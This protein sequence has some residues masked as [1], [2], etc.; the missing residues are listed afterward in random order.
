MKNL[1]LPLI[2][3]AA[4]SVLDAQNLTPA[5]KESDFRYLASLYS[6]FYAPVDWKKQMFDF[7]VSAIKPWLDRVAATKTDLDF[8]EVCVEYVASLNDT[9]DRFSLPSDFSATLGFTTDIYD[10]VLLIDSLNRAQL[11]LAKYPFTMGD[12]LVSVDG[13]DVQQLVTNFR[14]YWVYA[15]ASA[16]RR[17]AAQLIT[18]RPQVRMPHATDVFGKSADVVIRRQNGNLETYSIPWESTGTPLEVG[19]VPSPRVVFNRLTAHVSADAVPDYMT[20]LVNAQWSSDLEA[21]VPA[22]NGYGSRSPI[23]AVSFSNLGFTRRLGGAA[24]DFF[25]SGTFK[26]DDMTFGYIRIPSYA[27]SSTTAQ[28]QIFEG[29]ISYMNANTDGLIVDEMRNNGGGACFAEDIVARL[30]PYE[31][32]ATGF[33]LR[34]YWSLVNSFYSSMIAAKSAGAPQD[35]VDLYEQSYNTLLNANRQGLDGYGIAAALHG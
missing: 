19:P 23:F 3:I 29:E 9:H 33:Q 8:Y 17:I 15:N 26:Y 31:F 22:L 27:P 13:V 10:G 12:E 24:S 4:S 30:V 5:Q 14:K 2:L 25:Y 20:E 6:A 18:S 32:R 28:L 16:S 11:P 1:I 34:P 35:I 21:D 7:D